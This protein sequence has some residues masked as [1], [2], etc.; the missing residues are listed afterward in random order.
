[1]KFAILYNTAAYGTHPEAVIRVAQ[2]A[3]ACGF[4]SFLVPEHLVLYPGATLGTFEVPPTMAVADP[5]ELLA[6]VAGVTDRIVL[7]TAVLLLPYRHPVVLAKQLATIDILSRGRLQMITVG[8][9]TLKGEAAAVGVDFATRGRRADEAIDA[10]RKLWSG[11]ADGVSHSGEFFAFD[12]VCI[13][14][15]PCS[16]VLPIHIGG[17][18]HAAAR[19]A[20]RLGD[21]YFPGGMLTSAERAAQ[22]D[23]M[24][25]YAA[26]RSRSGVAAVHP[27]GI[28]QSDLSTA[29]ARTGG[30]RPAGGLTSDRPRAGA[31][32]RPVCLRRETPIGVSRTTHRVSCVAE[33]CT[34][35]TT[36]RPPGLRRS[37]CH[38]PPGRRSRSSSVKGNVV[39][40]ALGVGCSR[41]VSPPRVGLRVG[42]AIRSMGSGQRHHFET[43]RTIRSA[44]PQR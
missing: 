26:R 17:S 6:F 20:G 12:D 44:S 43:A 42:Q 40:A 3:E 41:W 7:G 10:L 27:L 32:G 21:G 37:P 25:S 22:L 18:S 33:P 23:I 8:L 19:R 38:L 34:N 5:L 14:P 30:S 16:A 24:R 35:E 4:E 15:K 13:F 39:R 29:Y 31:A 9:G 36:D 28:A 1:M 2:H 11:G